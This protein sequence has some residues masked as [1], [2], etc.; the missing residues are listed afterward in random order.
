MPLYGI[1]EKHDLLRVDH[2]VGIFDLKR[3][4][5]ALSDSW[6]QFTSA[7]SHKVREKKVWN[8][9]SGEF[10]ERLKFILNIETHIIIDGL[11]II[12]NNE[13]P[14]HDFKIFKGS[15]GAKS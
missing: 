3:S 4:S 8:P 15:E 13:S 2:L 11:L 9:T 1:I 7:L 10:I 12:N 6:I 14:V 5:L